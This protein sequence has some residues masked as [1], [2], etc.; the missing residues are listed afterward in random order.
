[1]DEVNQAIKMSMLLEE[2]RKNELSE[3]EAYLQKALQISKQ[4]EEARIRKLKTL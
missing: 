4:D 3:E 1:M 2:Q